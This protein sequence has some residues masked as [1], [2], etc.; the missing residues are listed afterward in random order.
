M[1]SVLPAGSTGKEG[2]RRLNRQAAA[3]L[4]WD[5]SSK[6]HNKKPLS[7]SF[8]L[9]LTPHLLALSP[10]SPSFSLFS[11]SPLPLSLSPPSLSYSLSLSLPILSSLSLSNP[12]LT[13]ASG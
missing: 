8:S 9:L 2:A 12:Y 13:R 11:L 6:T 4:D 3:D 10:R 5:G 1:L 7:F